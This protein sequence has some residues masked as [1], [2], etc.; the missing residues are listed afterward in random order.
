MAL[1]DGLI[2]PASLLQDVPRK[3]GDYRPGN[4]DSGFHGAC[5]T[6]H[7]GKPFGTVGFQHLD[8]WQV[9][10]AHQRFTHGIETVYL[11]YGAG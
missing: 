1:D 6:Q 8:G 5:V 11:R 4:F 7:P 9:E 2:H 3:T 10:R